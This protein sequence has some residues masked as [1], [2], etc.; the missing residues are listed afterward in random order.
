MP[1]LRTL[2][3]DL[4]LFAKYH[5]KR[6]VV[7][8]PAPETELGIVP[9]GFDLDAYAASLRALDGE[10]YAVSTLAELDYRGR[11]H[12]VLRI[13]TRNAGAP[14][15][16]L[17]LAGVH[18]NEHAGL[19]AVPDILARL[20]G[21]PVPSVE[22][23]VVTPVN[24]VGAAELSRYNAEGYDI[25]R[26]FERF[27]T[28]EARLVRDVFDERR[29]DFLVSLHEGPQDATF[30]FANRHVDAALAERL[31]ERLRSGGTVLADRDYFGL[32]L[33]PPGYAP[34]SRAAWAVSWLWAATLGMKATNVFADDR[35]VP[36]LTLESSWRLPDRASRVRAHVD[37]VLGVLD[38]LR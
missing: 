2:P 6:R 20:A 32:T 3:K 25:N 18:G 14:R 35:G 5:L 30:A 37:L 15:R 26:D 7:T 16:L 27:F 21:A 23:V 9:L 34:L 1:S 31:L 4:R 24:P 10:R 8:Y 29:P 11:P 12:P 22:L 38:E 28:P 19:L 36:E 33:D 13:A 17:V